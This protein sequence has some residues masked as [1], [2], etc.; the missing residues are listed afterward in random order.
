MIDKTKPVW[1]EELPCPVALSSRD[2]SFYLLNSAAKGIFGFTEEDLVIHPW[3]WAEQIHADDREKFFKS[4]QELAIRQNVVRCDYRFFPK[5][6]AEPSWIREVSV[7]ANWQPSIPWNVLSVF[8]EITDLQPRHSS[9]E[10]TT[11]STK[12]VK[13]LFHDL[14]N[15][16]QVMVMTIES[17]KRGFEKIDFDRLLQTVYSMKYSVENAQK[18]FNPP[19]TQ[20]GPYPL[21][22]RLGRRRRS[23]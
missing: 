5:G 6:M 16:L 12:M 9:A 14:Q 19:K 20:H 2:R 8:T 4:Q 7:I 11:K 17:A 1:L 21:T 15:R 10:R 22:R 23:P 18:G 13:T 3:L